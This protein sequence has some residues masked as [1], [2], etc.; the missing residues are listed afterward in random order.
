MTAYVRFPVKKSIFNW[1][2][3]NGDKNVEAINDKFDQFQ[4]WLSGEV[5]PTVKQIQ[6]FSKFTSVPFGYFFL[7]DPPKEEIPALKFRTVGN[8]NAKASRALIETL[9]EME[10]RQSWMKDYLSENGQDNP[11]EIVG[12]FSVDSR[13]NDV[14]E[15]ATKKLDI[16]NIKENKIEEFY[17]KLR[18]SIESQGILVMQNGVV[19]N[20]N[21]RSLKVSEFRAFVLIDDVVPLIFINRA[22]SRT[23]NIFSLVHEFVHVIIAKDEILNV[24]EFTEINKS[25]EQWIN[26]VTAGILV[27]KQVIRSYVEKYSSTKGNDYVIKRIA[28]KMHVS[29]I[30]VAIRMNKMKLC[31]GND[32]DNIKQEQTSLI[33]NKVKVS[34]GNYYSTQKSRIDGNFMYAVMDSRNSGSISASEASSLVGVKKVETYNALMKSFREDNGL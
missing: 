18:N 1:V 31:S 22:D 8:K 21:K 13:I 10:Y 30:V 11:I 20:Q 24:D 17:K 15:Y 27:P 9:N 23:A 4:K 2:I 33:N 3:E 34:G 5:E 28:Q 29:P 12:S 6:D 25:E 32:I 19:G 14:I 7:N 26:E 16:T